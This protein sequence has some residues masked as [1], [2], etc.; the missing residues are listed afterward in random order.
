MPVAIEL[1][2]TAKGRRRLQSIVEGYLG[3]LASGDLEQVWYLTDG[4]EVARAIKRASGGDPNIRVI[5]IGTHT[6]A[7]EPSQASPE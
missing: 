6:S 2:L 3:P 1:E 7:V 5:P 4:P